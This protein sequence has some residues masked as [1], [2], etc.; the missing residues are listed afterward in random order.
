MISKEQ[1][2]VLKQEA[3][4]QGTDIHTLLAAKM[5]NSASELVT[6]AQRDYAKRRV[7]L[8]AYGNTA[9][10][11]LDCSRPNIANGPKAGPER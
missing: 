8:W 4:E 9:G 2:E 10:S 5:F 11:R 7:F 6:S 3:L 1:Y